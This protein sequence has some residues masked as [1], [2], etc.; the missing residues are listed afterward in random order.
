[1][2]IKDNRIL[3]DA[4]ESLTNWNTSGGGGGFGGIS[5][6]SATV[7]EG[8]NS[9]TSPIQNAEAF[10]YYDAGG[11][12]D[13]SNN[14]FY[15]LMQVGVIGQLTGTGA[16]G[17]R[18]TGTTITDFIEFRVAKGTVDW[19]AT[20]VGKGWYQFVID[21][22]GPPTRTGGTPPATSSIQRV[23]FVSEIG[24][25]AKQD[26]HWIDAIYRRPYSSP[27]LIIEGTNGG[28][29]YTWQDV[30]DYC[31][32][33]GIAVFVP[34]PGGS[35]VV[36]TPIQIGNNTTGST[37]DFSDTNSLILWDTQPKA[38]TD[39]YKID[40]VN[41]SGST[42]DVQAGSKSGTGDDATG[43]QG[44]IIQ[45]A[46]FAN[47]TTYANR[48]SLIAN[49]VTANVNLY[50]CTF[51]H[52]DIIRAESSN[53]EVI[54]TFTIDGNEYVHSTTAGSSIFLRNTVINANTAD[55]EAY[56]KTKDFSKIDYST[57]EFSD[58]HAIEITTLTT[59][60]VEPSNE[61]I[62]T[63]YTDSVDSTDAA[64]YNN[65]GQTLE[66]AQ[67]GGNLPTNSYRDGT[68]SST[69]ITNN[70]TV[71]ITNVLLGSEVR[72]WN[73]AG[74]PGGGAPNTD[75]E[76][77]GGVES[78]ASSTVSFTVTGNL[79][80]L[81]KVFKTDYNIERFEFNTAAGFD[82]RVD[83]TIDRVFNNP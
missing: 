6:D 40:F 75:V 13:W 10:V 49:N 62:F 50:G 54:S 30:S 71:N 2:A 11:A 8:S 80:V 20:S 72:M 9:I 63:G 41:V 29:P 46:E 31:T 36:S 83:Q 37:H 23:G 15:F 73:Y 18:F 28:S 42:L 64:I 47:T 25:M 70:V 7:Y 26:N 53:T 39:S 67:S 81:V 3:I 78:A 77:A 14:E 38:N 34:G 32:Q 35:F 5:L 1:M 24:T 59:G 22:D 52:T 44:W 48:W 45:A 79:D 66:I 76:I 17:F 57:F 61:N 74:G 16:L 21:I 82:R 60:G 69:T 43:S 68:G 33:N 58:G 19:P 12:Q 4:A 51:A 55:G 65:S 27:G 56:L